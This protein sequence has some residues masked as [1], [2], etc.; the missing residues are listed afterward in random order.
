MVSPSW[1]ARARNRAFLFLFLCCDGQRVAAAA[2]PHRLLSLT[3][4]LSPPTNPHPSTVIQ[5]ASAL[6]NYG[7]GASFRRSTWPATGCH[8]TVARVAPAADGAHGRAWGVLMW[9]GVVAKGGPGRPVPVR[10][11]LKPVWVACGAEES[12]GQ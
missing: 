4:P 6:P 3:H 11:A 2:R 7:V 9:K 1:A 10:G 5:A 12:A 8:W